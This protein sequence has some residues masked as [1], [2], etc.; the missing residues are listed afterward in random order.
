MLFAP[1]LSAEAQQQGKVVKI[2]WLARAASA[3]RLDLFRRELGQLGYVE[4]KN[5]AIESRNTEPDRLS[6]LIDE[7]VRLKVDV[8]VTASTN[9]ALAAKNASSTI[10]I[11]FCNVTDPIAAGLVDS[12]ARP[13]RNITGITNIQGVLA[14]KR[15]ELLKETVPKLSRVAVL[16]N[17]E[18]LNAVQQWKE[19]QLPARDLRLQLHSME[20]NS[21][22]KF[23]S[24]FKVATKAGAAAVAVIGSPLIGLN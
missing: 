7:L 5:M 15:L 8:I 20:V 19:S 2:G 11:V 24:A 14:G 13:G 12:L 6:A 4:G 18:E 21:A 22:E 3:T 23:E 17:P 9:D 1:C 10:P 16:W